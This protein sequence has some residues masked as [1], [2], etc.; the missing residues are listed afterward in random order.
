M[1]VYAGLAE[2]VGRFPGAAVTIGAFDGVHRGHRR[3]IDQVRH[4]ASALGVPAVALTF[5]PHPARVLNPKLS[6][7]LISTRARRR[8][9][10]SDTGLQAT[11]EQPFDR[12]FAAI[13]PEQ[14][15][16]TLL[17][18]VGARAIVVG[19]DFTY[20]HRR[21]GTTETLRQACTRRG[22]TLDVVPAVT[23]DGL[24]VSSTK[25]REF[26]LSGN[27]EAASTL[28]GRPFDIE[29]IVVKGAARG[30]T[31][32]VPTA[33]VQPDLDPGETTPLIPGIGV[34]AT[35]VWLPDGRAFAGATNV[36][37]NPTFLPESTSGPTAQAISIEAHLLDHSSDLYGQKLRVAFVAR[38]R[39]ERW[40]PNV[41][42]LVTQI[43]ADIEATRRIVRPE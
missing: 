1:D 23:V 34:Y 33:N 40:F 38:L 3:L 14:F 28:L 8:Q 29:G 21:A 35:R 2:A 13:S 10:L 17:D 39:P 15:E 32:G 24:V 27:I 4:R 6:Q 9:L 37:V 36:G 5:W 22:A 25:I 11:I 26:V 19:Y 43:R 42:S 41:E 12:T 30:R 7:P 31:I 18:E 16:S 20:G